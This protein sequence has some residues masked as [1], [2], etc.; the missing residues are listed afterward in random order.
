MG[1]QQSYPWTRGLHGERDDLCQGTSGPSKDMTVAQWDYHLLQEERDFFATLGV[2]PLPRGLGL[3]RRLD[4]R[5]VRK[6]LVILL[7]LK[8]R[9][10]A[11]DDDEVNWALGDLFVKADEWF[12]KRDIDKWDNVPEDLL[13]RAMLRIFLCHASEDRQ[14]VERLFR[15]LTSLGFDVWFDKVNLLPGQTWQLEIQ[16]AVRD[17]DIVIVCL[18]RRSVTKQGYVHKER[19]VAL[20]ASSE[21]PGGVIYLVP[22]RL[23]A[24]RV[25]AELMHLQYVDLFDGDG[26]NK[27]THALLTSAYYQ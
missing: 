7:R 1:R 2:E 9:T 14:E 11:P 3:T 22:V 23:D 20:D 13:P 4:R 5:E 27:L 10:P 12:D 17:S 8:E 19:R 24:C 15:G 6:V 21:R 25:P 18:S 16:H 26:V